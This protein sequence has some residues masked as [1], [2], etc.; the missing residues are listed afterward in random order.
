MEWLSP[1]A[2]VRKNV[3]QDTGRRK[4]REVIAEYLL[5]E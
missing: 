5:T 1:G 2:A 3:L 4:I